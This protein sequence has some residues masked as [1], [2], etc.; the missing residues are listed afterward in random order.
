MRMPSLSEFAEM[1]QDQV[2][3]EVRNLDTTA[4]KEGLEPGAFDTV[5]STLS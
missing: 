4:L 3:R 1:G 2:R 5:T